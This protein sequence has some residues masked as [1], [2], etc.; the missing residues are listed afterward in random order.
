MTWVIASLLGAAVAGMN[1][2]LDKMVL[3]RY[4][5]SP[6]TLPC[7]LGL[8][9][10]I[11]AVILIPILTWPADVVV[12][13]VIWGCVSG[14]LL[15]VGSVVVFHVLYRQE[16]SR[17]SPILNTHPI[18]TAILA[19]VFLGEHLSVYHWIGIALT[20]SGAILL[21]L[22]KRQ[23]YTGIILHPSLYIL[24]FA[25]ILFAIASI[26]NKIAIEDL[27]ILQAHAVRSLGLGIGL[28]AFTLRPSSV[29]EI[30]QLVRQKSLG[31]G[32]VLTN[33]LVLVSFVMIV[34]NWALSLGP[35]SLVS[36]IISTRSLFVVIYSTTLSLRFGGILKEQ[37]SLPVVSVKL[38]SAAL[39][40][41][42]VSVI[43][44]IRS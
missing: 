16:V 25:G 37:I 12:S 33:V 32:I 6:L 36:T 27:S 11:V 38:F 10:T 7:L 9:V 19:V 23:D 4:I 20:V 1:S 35:V 44:F 28:L 17:T 31:L 13:A 3:V 22:R 14:L 30:L 26:A 18:I 29:D 41:A 34:T 2:I 39:I 5:R 24:L 40:V 43:G 15:G 42:G 21:S 8:I